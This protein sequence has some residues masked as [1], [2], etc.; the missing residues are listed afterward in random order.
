VRKADPV[1]AGSPVELAPLWRRAV[2]E[3]IHWA[4]TA[5]FLTMCALG[6]SELEDRDNWLGRQLKKARAFREPRWWPDRWLAFW[7]C[8]A[9]D[10]RNSPTRGQRLMRIR[11]VRLRDGGPVTITSAIVRYMTNGLLRASVNAIHGPKIRRTQHR[12]DAIRP[13]LDELEREYAGDQAALDREQ[14]AMLNRHEINLLLPVALTWAPRVAFH[15]L[16]V[17][18]SRNRQGLPD[19]LAGTAIA[20][21]D[22]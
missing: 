20:I 5:A 2:A 15:I 6:A 9:I 13:A 3:M 17:L 12:L 18:V 19:R 8:L 16:C 21:Q 11:R 4:I 1:I 10:L 7:L 14:T 22:P